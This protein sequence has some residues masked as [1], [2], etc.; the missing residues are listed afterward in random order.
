MED[1]QIPV[2]EALE[3]TTKA[4]KEYVDEN[5]ISCDEVQFLGKRAKSIAKNNVGIYVQ[6][7]EPTES[8]DGDIWVDP[9]ES[10]TSD[11]SDNNVLID[12]TLTLEGYAA[13]AKAV[14]GRL[15]SVSSSIEEQRSYIQA[16]TDAIA[17]IQR[18]VVSST[19]LAQQQLHT[20]TLELEGGSYDVIQVETD[21]ND[22]PTKI[23]VNNSIEIPIAV[24]E[25]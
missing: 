10:G 6:S 7:A 19:W 12:N 20:I 4:I 17:N 23:L 5:T 22:Y 15:S 18:S 13:D 1:K 9:S 3:L 16:N 8:V 21:E 24:R 14:G 25:A 2:S 11:D